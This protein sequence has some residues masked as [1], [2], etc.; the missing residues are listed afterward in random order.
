M[1]NQPIET[2]EQFLK[3]GGQIKVLPPKNVK[4]IR[5]SKF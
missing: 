3:R 4:R 1:K 5:W 2:V